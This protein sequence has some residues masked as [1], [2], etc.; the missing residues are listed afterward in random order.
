MVK[1]HTTFIQLITSGFVI[2]LLLACNPEQADNQPTCDTQCITMQ[3]LQVKVTLNTDVI[4]VEQQYQM[5]ITAKQPI[6]S[7]SISGSNMNMGT[8]P[9][10]L[11]LTSSNNNTYIYQS[12]FM[13]GLCSQ[14][15]MTWILNVEMANDTK[16]TDTA[17][18]ANTITE[19]DFV[20][21]WQRPK[22]N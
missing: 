18:L 12:A 21:Y 22:T 6:N 14:P 5:T 13:L 8:L 3:N 17:S 4:L 19:F 7:M 10:F 9:L 2:G 16:T 15:K 11:T 20:S 1:K